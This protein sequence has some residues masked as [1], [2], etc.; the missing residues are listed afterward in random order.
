MI[1][2]GIS[3]PT[4]QGSNDPIYDCLA[5]KLYIEVEL[6][7]T[8]YWDPYYDDSLTDVQG[9]FLDGVVAWLK[10]PCSDLGV[11]QSSNHRYWHF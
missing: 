7:H 4:V 2:N 3:R 10:W 5:M 9:K 11:A 8:N 6:N 1:S